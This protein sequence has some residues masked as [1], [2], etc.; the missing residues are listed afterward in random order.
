M[1][2]LLIVGIIV[3]LSAQNLFIQAVAIL[4]IGVAV[5]IID[6]RSFKG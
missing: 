3:M 4:I 2:A 1:N 5:F 6:S